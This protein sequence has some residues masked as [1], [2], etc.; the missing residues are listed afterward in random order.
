V[1]VDGP[2]SLTDGEKGEMV[3]QAIEELEADIEAVRGV[4]GREGCAARAGL[5]LVMSPAGSDLRS[6]TTARPS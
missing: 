6:K 1:V 4:A 5:A 2:T 3:G